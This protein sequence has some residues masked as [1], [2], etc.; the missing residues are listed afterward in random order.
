MTDV[1]A[2]RA[3]I[4][5]LAGQYDTALAVLKEDL[6][7][8]AP[9]TGALLVAAAAL[10]GLKSHRKALDL[11]KTVIAQSPTNSPAFAAAAAALVGLRDGFAAIDYADEAIR[12]D[13]LSP[14]AHA[15]RVQA[16]LLVGEIESGTPTEDSAV[17]L[18]RLAEQDPGA[19]TVIGDLHRHRRRF[20]EAAK[21]YQ[22]ALTID[23]MNEAAANNRVLVLFRRWRAVAAV[24]ALAAL[25]RAHPLMETA[26]FNAVIAAKVWCRIA[27]LATVLTLYACVLLFRGAPPLARPVTVAVTYLAVLSYA[28]VFLGAAGPGVRRYLRDLPIVD[29]M[30]ITQLALLAVIPPVVATLWVL[31]PELAHLLTLVSA[32]AL[33]LGFSATARHHGRWTAF[34][35]E[36]Q[37]R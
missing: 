8:S 2:E 18:L 37:P 27:T 5:V 3:R 36:R 16:G 31:A 20:S 35:E 7:S 25:L 34:V 29:P 19:L 4:L 26:R 33:T 10:N 32:L 21:F 15:W 24:R 13:P 28:T 22:R 30:L 12:L 6:A 9:S 23:P 1:A 11:A 14:N 17:Q